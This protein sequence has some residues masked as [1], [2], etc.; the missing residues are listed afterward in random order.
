MNVDLRDKGRSCSLLL[1]HVHQRS[2]SA[3]ADLASLPPAPLAELEPALADLEPA[4]FFLRNAAWTRGLL[5][6]PRSQAAKHRE[7]DISSG[8]AVT[9]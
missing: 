6:L 2:G 8:D 3:A 4:R 1:E 9:R 7:V 5:P